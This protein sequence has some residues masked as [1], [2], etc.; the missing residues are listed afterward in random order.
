[1]D[2]QRRVAR[3]REWLTYGREHRL[4]FRQLAARIGVCERTV[5]RWNK[6]LGNQGRLSDPYCTLPTDREADLLALVERRPLVEQIRSDVPSPTRIQ[7]VLAKE[8]TLMIDDDVDTDVLA[9]VIAAVE[10]C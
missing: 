5:R 4:T 8:R 6:A 7:I 2:L 1:M 10:R 3:A 9:R